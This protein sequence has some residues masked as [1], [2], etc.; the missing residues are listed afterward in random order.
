M[1]LAGK[2]DL[3]ALRDAGWLFESANG[4]GGDEDKWYGFY[5]Y[6]G[7]LSPVIHMRTDATFNQIYE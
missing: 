4:T 2:F 7:E 3:G 5:T 6:Y 1:V